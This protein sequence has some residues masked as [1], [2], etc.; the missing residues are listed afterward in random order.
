MVPEVLWEYG[1]RDPA[2]PTYQY[3]EV[4]WPTDADAWESA[5][6]SLAAIIESKAP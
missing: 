6:A 4:S 2:D 5:R 1:V 3:T